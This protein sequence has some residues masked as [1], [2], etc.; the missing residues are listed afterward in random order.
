MRCLWLAINL[1]YSPLYLPYIGACRREKVDLPG[2]NDKT[3]PIENILKCLRKKFLLVICEIPWRWWKIQTDENIIEESVELLTIYRPFERRS[4]TQIDLRIQFCWL[5]KNF[6]FI[7]V[8]FTFVW[9]P[10]THTR[11]I[12]VEKLLLPDFLLFFVN[13][14]LNHFSICF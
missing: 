12:F 7:S 10:H 5:K 13:R 14:V 4:L 9:P 3:A 8:L 2:V 11:R 1:K 6:F